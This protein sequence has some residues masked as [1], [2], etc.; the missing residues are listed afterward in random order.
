MRKLLFLVCLVL[1]TM[2]SSCS[3][4]ETIKDQEYYDQL[5]SCEPETDTHYLS[6]FTTYRGE[7]YSTSIPYITENKKNSEYEVIENRA[8]VIFKDVSVISLANNY[9]TKGNIGI[10]SF[11]W[12]YHVKFNNFTT[13]YYFNTEE[14]QT[15]YGIFPL[16][17]PNFELIKCDINN[18]GIIE[19]GDKAYEYVKVSLLL[20]VTQGEKVFNFPKTIMVKERRYPIEFNPSV[21]NWEN[22]KSM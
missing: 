2:I 14:H 13:I 7:K 18:L 20:K 17:E 21:D 19:E 5:C 1:G 4:V 12:M 6:W 11:E 15:L 9:Q 8:D 10:T 3:F 22:E 16:Y